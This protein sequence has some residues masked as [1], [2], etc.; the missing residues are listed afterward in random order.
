MLVDATG[1]AESG[2][3][4]VQLLVSDPLHLTSPH[5]DAKSW[6]HHYL[7]PFSRILKSFGARWLTPVILA[8]W[9]AEV[10]RSQGQEF[11]TSLTNMMK[12]HLH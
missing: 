5:N 8:L 7:S 12:H 2:D 9:E 11:E 1:A 10:G 6:R 4:C 3:L